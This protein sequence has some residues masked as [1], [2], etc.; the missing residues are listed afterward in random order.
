MLKE[1]EVTSVVYATIWKQN[2][3]KANEE[4]IQVA[5]KHYG[6]SMSFNS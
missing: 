4:Y 1:N 2:T 5:I 6:V 3:V